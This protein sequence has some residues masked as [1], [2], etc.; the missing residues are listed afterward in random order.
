[1]L[2]GQEKQGSNV[3]LCDSM[4]IQIVNHPAVILGLNV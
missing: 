3:G 2:S 4:R 1:M